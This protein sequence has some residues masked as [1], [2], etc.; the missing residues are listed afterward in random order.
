MYSFSISRNTLEIVL[1]A[2]MRRLRYSNELVVLASIVVLALLYVSWPIQPEWLNLDYTVNDDVKIGRPVAILIPSTTRDI[3]HPS[4]NTLSLTTICIPSLKG[5][6]ESKFQYRVY[7]GTEDDDY[8]VTQFDEL[9]AMSTANMQMIPIATEGG[10]FNKIVNALAMRAFHDGAEYFTRIN[11][12]TRF[13]TKNWTSVAVDKLRQFKPKNIGVVGPTCSEGKTAVMTHDMVHESHIQMF[14]FYYPPILDN[15]YIDDWITAVYMPNRS[16]KLSNWVVRHTLEHGTRYGVNQRKR[17]WV[18]HMIILGRVTIGTMLNK[19]SLRS[20]LQVISYSL[21][22]DES[23]YMDGVITNAKLAQ[24]IYPGW[25]VR[26]YHDDTVPKH[27]LE[28]LKNLNVQLVN[29]SKYSPLEH[30]LFW[31][32][33]VAFDPSVKRYIIRNTDSVLSWRERAAV[34]EWIA[35]GKDFHIMRDH[36]YHSKFTVPDG[37]WG[38]T[39]GAIPDI[40]NILFKFTE[41]QP[42]FEVLQERLRKEIWKLAYTSK[43]QHDSFSCEK[44]YDSLPFPTKRKGWEFVGNVKIEGKYI[45]EDV[46]ALKQTVQPAKCSK[47]DGSS[48]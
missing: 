46:E 29:I 31:R 14:N 37:L 44:Y 32:I 20:S 27:V 16:S 15:W 21:F 9:R 5:S 34:D 19:G 28:T 23:R 1:L 11:D 24:Q 47:R 40:T 12:D 22:G 25:I 3:K 35:S 41:D 17:N 10:N 39:H 36:P 7:I 8:L 13:I 45:Q 48:G 26:V 38:S 4:L 18:M 33:F 2:K 42:S 43:I 6:A 30:K